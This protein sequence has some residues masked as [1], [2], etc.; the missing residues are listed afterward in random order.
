MHSIL[1][2]KTRR[3]EDKEVSGLDKFNFGNVDLIMPMGYTRGDVQKATGWLKC[4]WQ[5]S[6]LF[7]CE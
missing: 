3:K 2:Y 6:E 4:S 7:K 5:Y 1:T